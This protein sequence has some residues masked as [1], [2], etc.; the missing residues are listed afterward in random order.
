MRLQP[1]LCG[2]AVL[3][4][5]PDLTAAAARIVKPDLPA[6]DTVRVVTTTVGRVY[7]DA[8]G[9]AL[10]N[11]Q[12][13]GG[14]GL[15]AGFNSNCLKE[16]A[17]AWPPLA[18][19][20]GDQPIGEWVPFKRSDGTL[21]WA[22]QKRPV[23]TRAAD[24]KVGEPAGHGQGAVWNVVHY[25][26]PVPKIPLPAAVQIRLMGSDYVLT[27]Y[28][29][30]TLYSAG[31]RPCADACGTRWVALEAPVAARPLE[32]WSFVKHPDG[33]RSWAFRGQPLYRFAD[34]V[35]PGEQG[36]EGRDGVW[37]MVRP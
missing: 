23:Y 32:G 28:R 2:A 25:V 24:S 21:Q 34:D 11:Y 16:C 9:K 13:D 3:L 8:A 35:K 31:R 17:E 18:A 5:G 33:T 12:G 19:S 14:Q 20:A 10:Y 36:G 29:G 7:A 4:T 27:D 22:Y 6:P 1:I 37:K 30:M 15:I 26:P